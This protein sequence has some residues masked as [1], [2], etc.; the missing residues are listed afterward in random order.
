MTLSH[1]S[2]RTFPL[3]AVASLMVLATSTPASAQEMDGRWLPFLGCWEP[4]GQGATDGVLCVEPTDD[5]VEL[6]TVS[7]GEVV[8][9][10][11]LVAD[12]TSRPRSIEGCEG[13]DSAGFSRDGRRVFTR[14][15][16]ICGE[17]IARTATGIMS[18]VAP[19]QWIDVRSMDVGGEQVAWVQSYRLVGPERMLQEGVEDSTYFTQDMGM[20]LQAARMYASRNIWLEDVV[21]AAE[22]VDTK[23][24]EAWVAER[25]ERFALDADALIKLADAGVPESI[26]DVVVAVSYPGTFA[27]AGEAGA[28]M[29]GDR[30]SFDG[31]PVRP[32]YG[33]G[34]Y[35]RSP[36]YNY[37]YGPYSYYGYS[38]YSRYSYGSLYGYGYQGYYSGYSS[39]RYY[40]PTMVTVNRRES[41][42]ES[43][44]R[45]YNGRGYR[46][47]DQG[48]RTG[49][50]QSVGGS[51]GAGTS[52]GSASGGSSTGR[53]A[54]PRGGRGG[55]GGTS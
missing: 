13:W 22:R 55:G 36:F 15:E 34:I 45:V 12:G 33:Y 43:G 31:R 38:P 35:S 21:E 1:F 16:F 30:R 51:S 25:G 11:L 37:G 52:T 42:P 17:E 40:M 53:T 18:L 10:D 48:S 28:S 24:V 46:A 6:Y 47:G 8:T 54:K 19:T 2:F 4:T 50:T 39:G 26:I 14:S 41:N 44:G 7:G 23:A 20:A 29:G 9:S 32:I 27:I 5:G 49:P 3:L